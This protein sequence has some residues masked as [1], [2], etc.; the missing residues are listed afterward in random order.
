V[1]KR[2]KAHYRENKLRLP[3]PVEIPF[4]GIFTVAVICA[5]LYNNNYLYVR[6]GDFLATT[7]IYVLIAAG[8]NALLYLITRNWIITN[9]LVTAAYIGLCSYD[10]LINRV[11]VYF[12]NFYRLRYFLPAYIVLITVL[13]IL[14]FII[15]TRK[16]AKVFNQFAS[17]MICFLF[18]FNMFGAVRL[19]LSLTDADF[20]GDNDWLSE[21]FSY[22]YNLN[23]PDTDKNI[24]F[25]IFDEM[26]SPRAAQLLGADID[27]QLNKLREM[28]FYVP[29]SD[30]SISIRQTLYSLPELLNPHGFDNYLKE[31]YAEVTNAVISSFH[32]AQVDRVVDNVRQRTRQKVGIMINNPELII[33]FQQRGFATPFN[34][35]IEYPPNRNSLNNQSTVFD[36]DMKTLFKST[37]V[38]IGL[39]IIYNMLRA[40]EIEDL[41]I[42]NSINNEG[43]DNREF[44]IKERI[45]DKTELAAD[46]NQFFFSHFLLPHFPFVY[47]AD[48]SQKTKEQLLSLN[49]Q[50]S[51]RV[52]PSFIEQYIFTL[53]L[54]IEQMETVIDND[55]EAVIVIIGD[56]GFGGNFPYDALS[57]GLGITLNE[58]HIIRNEIFVA[59]R[60]GD[61]ADAEN[62][63]IFKDPRNITRY[64]VNTYVG[65]NYEY[66]LPE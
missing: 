10:T 62:N 65:Q 9:F 26:T 47:N 31:D 57:R 40:V 4:A 15:S 6:F 51:Y 61:E 21:Y 13:I 44:E 53:N 7:L 25:F 32:A 50:N 64:L 14:A 12:P 16:H 56:H 66:I 48:G 8:I 43:F 35:I 33:A 42:I 11:F 46:K 38:I 59:L 37:T 45:F 49:H 20:D 41:N 58:A 54:M 23:A 3:K 30:M 60:L 22:T 55:P 5:F 24:Y 36:S 1:I 52:T 28:G 18:V 19:H 39:E 2:V 29:E 34:D 17:I 27:E 63:P